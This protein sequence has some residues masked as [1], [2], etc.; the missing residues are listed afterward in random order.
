[1]E[2]DGGLGGVSVEVVVVCEEVIARAER[3]RIY[4]SQKQRTLT[5]R[6]TDTHINIGKYPLTL[7]YRIYYDISLLPP[8]VL[9]T[10]Y[11]RPQNFLYIMYKRRKFISR[12]R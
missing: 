8:I 1:M 2:I 6:E 7:L 4:I 11:S 12:L 3:R 9:V 5:L 10:I